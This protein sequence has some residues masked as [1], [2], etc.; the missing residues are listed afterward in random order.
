MIRRKVRKKLILGIMRFTDARFGSRR[1]RPLYLYVIE[2]RFGK[3]SKEREGSIF[4]RSRN[5]V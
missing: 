2:N 5:A 1:A 4:L 3:Y